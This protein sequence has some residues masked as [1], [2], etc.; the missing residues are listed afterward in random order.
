MH[1]Y[2]VRNLQEAMLS[3]LEFFPIV[4]M[5]GPRQCGKFTLARE[6]ITIK[7]NSVYLD[8]ESPEDINKLNN[9]EYFFRTNGGRISFLY[10]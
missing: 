7:E 2:I 9:P 8:L 4:A 10:S 6:I 5:L 1:G 3:N